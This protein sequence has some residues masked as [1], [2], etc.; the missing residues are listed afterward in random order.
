MAQIMQI[1]RVIRIIQS[2][3]SAQSIRAVQ[4]IIMIFLLSGCAIMLYRN[5]QAQLE[6]IYCVLMSELSQL[7]LCRYSLYDMIVSQ[8]IPR[9][10]DFNHEGFCYTFSA[11]IMLSLRKYRNAR[12]VRGYIDYRDLHSNHSWVEVRILGVWLVVDP[13]IMI[14]GFTTRSWYYRAIRPEV[15]RVYKYREFWSDPY[16]DEFFQRMS[17][18]KTSHVFYNLCQRYTPNEKGSVETISPEQYQAK[19]L[20]FFDDGQ[21][22]VFSPESGFYCEQSIINEL[23]ARP[24]RLSPKR[25]TIRRIDYSKRHAQADSSLRSPAV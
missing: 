25:H 24:T 5:R 13:N 14:A 19:G 18:Q 15:K 20:E 6:A 10:T 21:H 12:L 2:I 4:G 8:F 22:Y 1:V 3:Q 17:V 23:M 11:A 16:A 7:Y 9:F